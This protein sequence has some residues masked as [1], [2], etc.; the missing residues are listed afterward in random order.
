MPW[1]CSRSSVTFGSC[2]LEEVS[3]PTIEVEII[4]SIIALVPYDSDTIEPTQTLF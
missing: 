2:R 1:T 3:H 4:T